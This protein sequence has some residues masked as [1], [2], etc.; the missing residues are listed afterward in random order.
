M[1]GIGS[2]DKT[3][4]IQFH[5]QARDIVSCSTASALD[6][7]SLERPHEAVLRVHTTCK[8]HVWSPTGTTLLAYS[9]Q[10][11]IS[12]TDP[13]SKD[14]AQEITTRYQPARPSHTAFLNDTTIIATGTA[15]TR[16]LSLYDLRS[17]LS[18]KQTIQFDPAAPSVGLLPLPDRAR[19][20]AY[21]VQKHSSS[22]YAFDFN[23][24]NALPTTLQVPSTIV[25]AA[26]LPVGEVDVMRAE[27]NRLFILT[28]RH[29]I[30]PV[31]VRVER[32]VRPP[33]SW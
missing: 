11:T 27:I 24:A 33:L 25:D 5:S 20:V 13:R 29:E 31:S 10:N 14:V 28:R 2:G 23:A 3:G 19:N 26:M 4:T 6:V 16:T 17:P 15:A 1:H 12:I 21:I 30:V 22:V 18:P 9:P 32:K 8:Q 7:Y